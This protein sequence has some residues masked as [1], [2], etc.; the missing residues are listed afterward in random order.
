ME[1]FL[2]TV[3][4][5]APAA[6]VLVVDDNSPDGT[7]N[8]AEK[9]AAEL[10]GIE[11]LRRPG[12][13]GLGTAYRA[14]FAQALAG[15]YDV[16]VQMDCDL[17]HDP[18][19]IPELVEAVT[20]GGADCA[21]GSRYVPGGA[22]PNWPAHRRVLSRYGNRYTS[23][24]LGLG[25]ADATSGFRAY[26]AA[27]LRAIRVETTRSSGYAFMSELAHRM[28]DQDMRMVEVPITFVD[29]TEGSSK[30]S[31]RIILESMTLVTAWGIRDRVERLRG[32]STR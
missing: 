17:S 7:A 16:L 20:A 30:M 10:G 31:A 2:T 21:I 18:A 4:G 6:D 27:S 1:R 32:R 19:V 5:A 22:T 8:R 15:D 24:V 26:R 29:R 9:V 11:V 13:E 14:G 28:V 3:R 25:I 23:A 12:K